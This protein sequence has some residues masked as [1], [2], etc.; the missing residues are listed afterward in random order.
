MVARA[1]ERL[2]GESKAVRARVRFV[3]G[4]M[5]QL[6]LRAKFD[7]VLCTFNTALHLYGRTDVEAF[8]ARV[9][10]HLAPGGQFVCDLSVPQV[11]DLARDPDQPH[12][13]PR[14]RHPTS[15]EVVRYREYFH[16]DSASQV[17][18]VSMVFTP[19]ARPDA[20]FVVPLSQ[21]QYFPREWEALLHYNG[22]RTV[23]LFGGFDRR[24]FDGDSDT[25]IWVAEQRREARSP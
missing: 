6:R 17:L 5:R 7:F 1:R 2:A 12:A 4:D 9:R 14:F 19:V 24:A 10:S 8:L 22:F 18:D 3:D 23:A 21:R 25:M 20:E 16:Y 11:R 15:G 13:T